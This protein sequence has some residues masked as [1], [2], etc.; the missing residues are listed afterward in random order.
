MAQPSSLPSL[1]EGC[2]ALNM[3]RRLNNASI[4]GIGGSRGS[5]TSLGKMG[6]QRSQDEAKEDCMEFME[7]KLEPVK[8]V[9]VDYELKP[10]EHDQFGQIFGC[11]CP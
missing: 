2:L 9:Q 5:N 8:L 10:H 7:P 4:L 11:E 6:T 1:S 3:V